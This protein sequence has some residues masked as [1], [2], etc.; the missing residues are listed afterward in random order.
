ML[1]IPRYLEYVFV[2][3]GLW[4]F[5][6]NPIHLITG[7]GAGQLVD[8]SEAD[9]NFLL[10]G[11]STALHAVSCLGILLRWKMIVT[12]L[13][14]SPQ[15]LLL[16]VFLLL[17][18]LSS[19]WSVFP[20]ISS[21]RSILLIG[22]TAFSAYFS[23]SF[24]F[25]QQVKFLII[26]LC[27][28]TVVCFLFGVLLPKYGI[29]HDAPH[30]GAWRGVYTHK[31]KLGAQMA[32]T[33][34][35]LLITQYTEIFRGRAKLA[36]SGSMV[37]SAFLV[38]AATSTTG[39]LATATM[40]LT[41][42]VCNALMLSYRS[43]VV[44]VSSITLTAGL[45]IFY[46][47]TNADAFFGAFG[48]GTDLSGRSD[49]WPALFHMI[50]QKP[51]LG[52]GYNGFWGPYGAPADIVRQIAG[53]PVPNAHNGFIEVLLNLGWIGGIL[54]FS[55]FLI[56]FLR[57]LQLIRMT[58]KSYAIY[59]AVMMVFLILSNITES[60]L[61]VGDSWIL[62]IWASLS[63]IQIL[64]K[65]SDDNSNETHDLVPEIPREFSKV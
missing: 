51:F 44:A 36:I 65:W 48:K 23:L 13:K 10:P 3:F 9:S 32:L 25:K 24:S 58:K 62:Y 22:A 50:S 16:I 46:I 42:F 2:C 64:S 33:T 26:A 45:G 54:F 1:R 35:F 19:N 41:F 34:V 39:L 27:I 18:V 59:P 5:L 37:L 29:M 28:N 4:F 8:L 6:G 17:V 57:S 56:T 20:N 21:R 7:G 52:Y 38:V 55:S 31:N 63:S 49:I 53:W 43:M 11:I 47:Q 14:S 12:R 40:T 60:N 15:A 30:T 61:F